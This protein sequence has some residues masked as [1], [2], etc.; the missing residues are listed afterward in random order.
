MS[1]SVINEKNRFIE[2]LLDK[3]PEKA[4]KKRAGHIVVK[5]PEASCDPS[6]ET[7]ATKCP[8]KSNVK[9]VPGVM[10]ARGC[11]YAGSKGVVWGPVR[12]C[13]HLSHGPVGCGYYSWSTRRN[14]AQ[15]VHSF[16][17]TDDNLARN[18]EWESMFDRLIQLR[19]EEGLKVKFTIQVDTMCHKIP[20]FIEKARRA[21]V[22]KA[23]IGLELQR[24]Q[25]D[26]FHLG[27]HDLV[28]APGWWNIGLQDGIH[29]VRFALTL[30]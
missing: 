6:D 18:T 16:F 28:L 29:G 12:D 5:K 9:S 17:L 4:R 15:G 30:E 21:G 27:R 10:T 7:C 23:F 25:N 20:G 14:L 2:E 19:E 13:V 22:K 1:D 8:I 26:I 11:A 24:H 3:Y